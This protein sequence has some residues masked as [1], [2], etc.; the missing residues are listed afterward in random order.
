[1]KRSGR[2]ALYGFRVVCILGEA[3]IPEQS[4]G[5][6]RERRPARTQSPL[7]FLRA[8]HSLWQVPAL[9]GRPSGGSTKKLKSVASPTPQQQRA[10]FCAFWSPHTHCE[11]RASRPK[12]LK[13]GRSPSATAAAKHLLRLSGARLFLIQ[14]RPVA[15]F[16]RVACFPVRNR[17]LLPCLV[18]T[19][20]FF[21]Y[22]Y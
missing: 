18:N 15:A 1:M 5:E 21:S 7:T 4:S 9:P 12:A 11:P 16:P 14:R 2:S 19:I 3:L 6:K 13:G 20:K 8:E 10:T 17:G 22:H